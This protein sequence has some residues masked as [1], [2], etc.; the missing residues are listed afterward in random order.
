[1]VQLCIGFPVG[2][3]AKLQPLQE[4]NLQSHQTLDRL[5]RWKGTETHILIGRLD[6]RKLWIGFPVGREPKR[7]TKSDRQLVAQTFSL[8]FF[9]FCIFAILYLSSLGGTATKRRTLFSAT[10]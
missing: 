2:R 4:K 6:V 10:L 7:F 9:F 1:M 8:C 5:S 3:E